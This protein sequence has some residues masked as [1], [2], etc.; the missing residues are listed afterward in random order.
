MER[1]NSNEKENKMYEQER[2]QSRLTH[3]GDVMKPLLGKNTRPA[4]KN[5]S[6]E[7]GYECP[8]CRDLHYVHP[9]RE[10]GKVDYSRVVS[11]QCAVERHERE[12]R[13]A[14]LRMCEVPPGTE[15]MTFE[16]FKVRPGLEEAYQA[17]LGVAEES[18]GDWLTLISDVNRG[19]THLVIATCRRRVAQ[20]KPAR[21]AYVPL[22]LEEL[23]RGFRHEGDYS[24][25]SRFDFFLNVPLLALD[26]LGTEHQTDWVR[27]KLDTIIDYRLTHGLGLIVN[28]NVTLEE[29]NFR[30]RSR[31]ER[32]GAIVFIDAP[33]FMYSKKGV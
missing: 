16:N 4:R 3:I 31:L 25:E 19:K 29:L 10:D 7:S 12:K 32:G 15:H 11:C 20:G 17:A 5:T 13:Q 2:E 6:A 23:R 28:A 24:Y 1:E 9:H 18:T 27:E 33:E 21:Y 14:V 22:L 26:D 30:I 8:I